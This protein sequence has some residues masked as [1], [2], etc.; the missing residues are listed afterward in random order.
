MGLLDNEVAKAKVAMDAALT[1]TSEHHFVLSADA[2]NAAEAS[3][4]R[5]LRITLTFAA[6]AAAVIVF[7]TI[8]V[9]VIAITTSRRI[10]RNLQVLADGSQQVEHGASALKAGSQSLA[11]GASEQAASLEETGA[12]LTE[13]AS[14]TERNAAGAATARDTAAQAR[15]TA[16][17]GAEQMKALQSAMEAICG[18]SIEITK[19]LKTID[20]IAFQTNILSLNAAVEAARAGEAG[21]GFAV[22]ADE[23][24]SLAQRSAVAARETAGKIEDSVRKS[25]QGVQI[26]T[27]VRASF[28]SIQKQVRELDTLVGEIAGSS[29]EQSQGVGQINRA[30]SQMDQVTQATAA[31]AEETAAAAEELNSHASTLREAISSLVALVGSKM[32]APAALTSAAEPVPPEPAP[33]P[34]P[35]LLSRVSHPATAAP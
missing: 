16:D 29:A 14:Q 4:S 20:E 17:R 18:A 27:E 11:R 22:V 10:G 12:S 13:M 15:S 21:L 6:V 25:Q 34:S 28:D 24:R 32:P 3:V 26:S 31:N 8:F 30:V 23:V 2:G 33:A 1:A 35:R 9:Q 19:I 7:A 5:N